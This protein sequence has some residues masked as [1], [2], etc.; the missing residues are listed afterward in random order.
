MCKFKMTDIE[1][2]IPRVHY[3]NS[4]IEQKEEFTEWCL[5]KYNINNKIYVTIS[6]HHPKS[7]KLIYIN[8]QGEQIIFVLDKKYESFIIEKIYWYSV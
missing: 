2:I 6:I 8:T 7:D 3:S 1:K 5:T 4:V